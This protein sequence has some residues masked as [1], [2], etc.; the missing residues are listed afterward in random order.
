MEK[1]KERIVA[2]GDAII[3]IIITIIVLELP[4]KLSAA[5]EVDMYILFRSIGIYFI[6]FC[7]VAD[8][9]YQGAQKFNQ[10]K[11]V[12]NKDFV[13]YMLF[14]FTLSLVPTFTRLLIEDT[15]RQVVFFYGI[16]SFIVTFLWTRLVYS[17]G[18]QIEE[19]DRMPEF[20]R[21]RENKR[22]KVLLGFRLVLLVIAYF[23]PR[24]GLVVYLALPIIGFMQ[25]II[26]K[27]EDR[28]VSQMNEEQKDYY[29]DDLRRDRGS[30]VR[31][32]M[33]LLRS[34]LG[35]DSKSKTDK[36][37][38]WVNFNDQWK[39]ELERQSE[40]L[41]EKIKN[42]ANPSEKQR[43]EREKQRLLMEQQKIQRIRN[44]T[45]ERINH[46]RGK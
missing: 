23:S 15:N 10:I 16:L 5:G 41:D 14:L 35:D 4:I 11:K 25:N 9:W 29:V 21:Q 8:L 20:F 1:M 6:S 40:A 22:Q 33:E 45:N 42:A 27:E 13:I 31:K 12:K 18:K 2:F 24:L 3:A 43:F 34:S 30:N 37:Q 46:S 36:Q 26:D 7:F 38:W 17:L 44:R 19:K 39:N 28:Y 32:Y